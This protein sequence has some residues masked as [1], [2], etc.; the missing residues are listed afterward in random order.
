[1]IRDVWKK[2][3][4]N[5]IM[6]FSWDPMENNKQGS[7]SGTKAG[8]GVGLVCRGLETRQCV[9]ISSSASCI[10]IFRCRGHGL[11]PLYLALVRLTPYVFS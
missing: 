9:G 5:F 6:F 8:M 3:H 10:I 4:I 7:T 2:K 11:L 1:M